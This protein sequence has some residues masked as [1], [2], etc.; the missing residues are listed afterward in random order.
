[1]QQRT[2]VWLLASAAQPTSFDVLALTSRGPSG[3]TKSFRAAADFSHV[4][5]FALACHLDHS[6][7]LVGLLERLLAF[8]FQAPLGAVEHAPAFADA[9]VEQGLPM[10]HHA[11]CSHIRTSPSNPYGRRSATS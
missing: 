3:T 6:P 5:G 10:V 1:M 2:R 8:D 9:S 7:A 4:V 11:P